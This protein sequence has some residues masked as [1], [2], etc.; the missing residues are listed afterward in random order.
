MSDNKKITLIEAVSDEET[1]L[2]EE[3]LMDFLGIPKDDPAEDIREFFGF[4]S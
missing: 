4:S 1:E 2:T 3:E